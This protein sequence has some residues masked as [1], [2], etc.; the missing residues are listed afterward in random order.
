MNATKKNILIAG[1]PGVG[2][3]SAVMRLS[4]ELKSFGPVGFYTAEI[5]AG[6]AR[7]GFELIS[8]DG[9]KGMLS[10]VGAKGPPWVGKYGVDVKSFEEFI[11]NLKLSVPAVN[12]VV[13]DEIGK[14][15]C[16]SDK[17]KTLVQEL[18]NSEKLVIATIA[19]KGGDFIADVKK[20]GDI[21]LFEM[22]RGN[23]DALVEEILRYIKI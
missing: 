23:R 15:E 3:T 20:R 18:L 4:E 16:L 7:Q 14:M 10:H 19:E 11:D 13:I 1:L 8:L 6:G 22:T 21:K 9:R 17:F 12:L 2:K 5:R